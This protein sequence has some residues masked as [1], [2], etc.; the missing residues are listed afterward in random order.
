MGSTRLP[1]KV[2]MNICGKPLL[3]WIIERVKETTLINKIIIATTKKN[4]DHILAEL[5]KEYDIEAFRGKDQDVLERFYETACFFIKKDNIKEK[6]LIIARVCADNPL[7]DPWE[8]DRAIGFFLKSDY[9]YVFNHIPAFDNGYPNGLGAEVF[10]FKILKKLWLKTNK[11]THREH[12]TKYIWDNLD[13]FSIGVI[14]APQ[15]MQGPSIKLDVNTKRDLSL[16]KKLYTKLIEKY[17]NKCF[18]SVEIIKTARYLF[19]NI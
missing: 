1:G 6:D 7:V 15:S 17:N 8:V 4:Q 10:S 16:I 13:C 14:K 11:K 9:D 12:V 2:M 19:K 18:N 5:A 3:G